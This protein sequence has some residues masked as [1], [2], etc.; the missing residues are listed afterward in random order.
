MAQ[1]SAEDQRGNER[2]REGAHPGHS[3]ITER[4]QKEQEGSGDAHCQ[5]SVLA[6]ARHKTKHKQR[7]QQV[8]GE[9]EGVQRNR[10]VPPPINERIFQTVN[11][12]GR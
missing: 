12:S 1:E 11:G 7:V 9:I 6:A 4:K 8:E 2:V 10:V 3:L 5:A